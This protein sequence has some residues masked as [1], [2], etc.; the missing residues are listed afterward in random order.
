MAFQGSFK[1]RR[2]SR[3]PKEPAQALNSVFI[4]DYPKNSIVLSDI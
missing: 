4:S 3:K 2:Q 1:C